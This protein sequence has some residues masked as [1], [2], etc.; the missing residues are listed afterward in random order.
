MISILNLHAHVR[1]HHAQKY[2]ACP[3]ETPVQGM[4]PISQCWLPLMIV[5]KT[6]FKH[7]G[8][9]QPTIHVQCLLACLLTLLLACLLA[10]A[11]LL[12]SG[13]KEGFW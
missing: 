2:W 10:I 3:H 11:L 4:S 12:D 6:K 9:K 5:D 1:G 13:Q 8:H 7:D